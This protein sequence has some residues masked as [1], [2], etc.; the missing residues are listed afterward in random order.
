MNGKNLDNRIGVALFL[1]N[2]ELGGAEILVLNLL[3]EVTKSPAFAF[4]LVLLGRGGRLAATAQSMA[5]S[6]LIRFRELGL[7]VRYGLKAAKALKGYVASQGISLI[8]SHLYDCDKTCL[9]LKLI[10]PRVSIISTKHGMQRHRLPTAS[11]DFI[12]Q[13]L[14]ARIVFISEP[15]RRHY[16]RNCGILFRTSLIENGVLAPKRFATGR[17]LPPLRIACIGSLRPEKGQRL[18]LEALNL[19]AAEGGEFHCEFFG[20]GPDRAGLERMPQAGT[21]VVFHGAFPNAS[22]EL[23]RFDLLVVPSLHE[24]FSLAMLESFLARLPVIASDCEAL[25]EKAGGGERAILFR[26]G[27]PAD[28]ARKLKGFAGTQDIDHMVERAYRYA[29]GFTLAR[30]AAR[31]LDLYGAVAGTPA[32]AGIQAGMQ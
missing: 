31:Y 8:H 4:H 13:F 29:S 32:P 7:P 21:R 20:D 15:Q 26:S 23:H 14:F 30:T 19:L 5:A 11:S 27:E 18:L 17:G 16:R 1:P 22:E 24:G 9:I 10:H 3:G 2:L 28:L 12:S 25:S 6:G